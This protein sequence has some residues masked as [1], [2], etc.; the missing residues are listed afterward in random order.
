MWTVLICVVC[1][2]PSDND[3]TEEKGGDVLDFAHVI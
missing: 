3:N 2:V 1:C